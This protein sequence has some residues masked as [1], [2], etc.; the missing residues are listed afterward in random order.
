LIFP[1]ELEGLLNDAGF[2]VVGMYDNQE[3]KESALNGLRLYV[4]AIFHA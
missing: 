2:T 4:V 3:L 1:L